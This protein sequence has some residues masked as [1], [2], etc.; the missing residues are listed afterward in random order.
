M[1][2]QPNIFRS[3]PLCLRDSP[4]RSFLI[5]R[6]M[7]LGLLLLL[8]PA[9]I[10]RADVYM[11][12]GRGTQAM[13]Q[14]GGTLLQSSEVRINGQPGRLSV[15]GF[16]ASPASLAPD[17]R[18]ALP[19]PE[20]NPTRASMATHIENGQATTLLLLPGA[21]PRSCVAILIEQSAE[22]HQK[23]RATPAEWPGSIAYPGCTPFFSAEYAQ[24]RTTLAVADTADAPDAATRRMDALLTG[25]GWARLPQ[26]TDASG[27]KLY[28]RGSR[29][30]LFSA[31]TPEDGGQTRI[32][33]L[34]R[35]GASP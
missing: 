24:T 25:D 4:C 2:L 11:R 35:V 16:D 1:I 5:A 8:L 31:T 28:T 26:Q 7:A 13:E 12:L 6:A 15:F 21:G 22:A 33:V 19:L 9:T 27:M 23:S 34:Q 17:L 18:K 14:L 10:A 30:C 32:T 29:I 20:L 3:V